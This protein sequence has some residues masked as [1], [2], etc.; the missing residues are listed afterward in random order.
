MNAR[1][2][3]I[4]DMYT[5]DEFTTTEIGQKLSITAERVRQILVREGVTWRH[6]GQR[7]RDQETLIALERLVTGEATW[8]EEAERLGITVSGLESRFK[9]RGLR[10]G[11][12][13]IAR[14]GE[15]SRYVGGCRC[16]FCK[17]ANTI[18]MREFRHQRKRVNASS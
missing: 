2:R 17:R 4:V 16:E 3:L 18:Y 9:R 8:K 15:R 11:R 12:I 6:R 5:K 14:H 13:R 10:T 1:D 7:E